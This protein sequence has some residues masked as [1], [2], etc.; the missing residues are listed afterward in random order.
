MYAFYVTQNKSTFSQKLQK[1]YCK[2]AKLGAL[3]LEVY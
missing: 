1:P 3:P 2:A